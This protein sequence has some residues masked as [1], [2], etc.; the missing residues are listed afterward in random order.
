MKNK[1]TSEGIG[2]AVDGPL[3]MV[4]GYQTFRILP[5]RQIVASVPGF[6]IT[7]VAK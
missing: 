7:D 4:H 2:I 1:K 3:V 5:V 6:L